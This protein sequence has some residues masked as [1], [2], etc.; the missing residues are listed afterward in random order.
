VDERWEELLP[1]YAVGALDAT[2][3]AGVE[4]YLRADPTARSRLAML[5]DGAGALAYTVPPM[6][7]PPELKQELLARIAAETVVPPAH[8]DEPLPADAAPAPTEPRPGALERWRQLLGPDSRRGLL[9]PGVAVLAL[10]AL[11]V[12]GTLI[13]VQSGQLRR[14]E[15]QLT[16]NQAEV[17][18]LQARQAAL[19]A[20][21][22]DPAALRFVAAG[23]DK[24]PQASGQ[25]IASPGTG[26]GVAVLRGL[27]DLPESQTYQLWLIGGD[28]PASAG[29]FRVD[30]T[31]NGTLLFRADPGLVNDADAVGV[32]VEPAGGSA[33]PTGDIVLLGKL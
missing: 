3:Q 1:L 32:S 2:E 15:A 30:A 19:L 28:K 21:L 33:Q 13:A 16:A 7:P 8:D 25:V 27:A 22:A 4:A 23:T 24:R 12:L 9:W 5:L 18:E 17:G 6:S 14:L 29:T 26:T 10:L 31:G 20:A 11:A